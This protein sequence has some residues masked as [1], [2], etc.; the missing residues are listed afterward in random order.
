MHLLSILFLASNLFAAPVINIDSGLDGAESFGSLSS[1]DSS[2]RSLESP[3]QI[4]I[5]SNG[6]FT[7]T[8]ADQEI[9]P[10]YDEVA[11]EPNELTGAV[12]NADFYGDEVACCY[13]A[14]L[15]CTLLACCALPLRQVEIDTSNQ[16]RSKNTTRK[17][18]ECNPTPVAN[19]DGS[20]GHDCGECVVGFAACC[21]TYNPCCY[22]N[23]SSS[24]K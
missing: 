16:R 2:K 19:L 21:L 7:F 10:V 11:L 6:F 12:S 24:H 23:C 8:E 5:L 18:I 13:G 20:D 17:T 4:P 15:T 9:T 14:C 22:I 1:K 3:Q